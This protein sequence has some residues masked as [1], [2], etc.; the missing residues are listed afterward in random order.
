MS[1]YGVCDRAV[2]MT[3]DAHTQTD[4]VVPRGCCFDNF[5]RNLDIIGSTF[6]AREG[7]YNYHVPD[8][9]TETK[10]KI[11][12]TRYR[13]DDGDI[14]F[15]TF[16]DDVDITFSRVSRKCNGASPDLNEPRKDIDGSL[17]F[18]IA[19]LQVFGY[20][21]W[22]SSGRKPSGVH[23]QY[24]CQLHDCFEVGAR[25][26]EKPTADGFCAESILDFLPQPFLPTMNLFGSFLA[27][28]KG[29]RKP[30]RE[31]FVPSLSILHRFQI[32][33]SC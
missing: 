2:A 22:R 10:Q 7:S 20:F 33:A 24:L 6:V 28:A 23:A 1:A 11:V 14:R 30:V 21:I 26:S 18:Y 19:C 15:L 16:D 25:D 27:C 13:E 29:L 32:S 5:W 31:I 17:G 8:R 4:A 12:R 3:V 9:A